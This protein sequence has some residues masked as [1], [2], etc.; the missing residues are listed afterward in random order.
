[1]TGSSIHDITNPNLLNKPNCS[2]SENYTFLMYSR[3][4]KI[5]IDNSHKRRSPLKTE[6]FLLRVFPVF[7]TNEMLKQMPISNSLGLGHGFFIYLLDYISLWGI[8]KC[9]HREKIKIEL[10]PKLYV[11]SSVWL[12]SRTCYELKY[13]IQD[14]INEKTW[15][16]FWTS[17]ILFSITCHLWW[18]SFVLLG[19]SHPAKQHR[20]FL[21]YLFL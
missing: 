3:H 9:C 21:P 1:M 12:H 11:L 2:F 8:L 17:Y 6:I 19:L 13:Q 15:S 5:Y 18:L 20:H 16:L 7:I 10:G 14:E 4:S